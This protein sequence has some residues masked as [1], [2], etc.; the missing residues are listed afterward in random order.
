M[1]IWVVM[2]VMDL[3]GNVRIIF[4]LMKLMGKREMKD[5]KEKQEELSLMKWTD[6][7]IKLHKMVMLGTQDAAPTRR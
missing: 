6:F 5:K 4:V 2:N 1:N 7:A 3:I